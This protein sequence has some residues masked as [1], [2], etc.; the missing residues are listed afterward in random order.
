MFLKIKKVHFVGIGGIGMSG[1]AEI[2]INKGF[3]V[4]GSD[5]NTS[6]NTEH[7]ISLSAKIFIGH[8]T[9]NVLNSDLV[10]YSSAIDINS[11]VEILKAKQ[12]SIPIIRRAEMLAE[13]SRLNYCIA[14]SG[15]HGKT[16]S[17]SILAMILIKA[18][19]DPTVLV[20]GR[21]KDLGGTN[22]R[23]GHSE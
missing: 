9:D 6:E 12:L 17:T 8:N 11:N 10:V 5:K 14:V 4:S 21:L 2:L 13:I 16:T 1:I 15:T 23:L 18:G 7:L 22:A 19:I 3:E 20:G